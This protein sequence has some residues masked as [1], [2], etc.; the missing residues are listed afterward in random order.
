MGK[1]Q[2][3][4]HDTGAP[5]SERS[6]MDIENIVEMTI[7]RTMPSMLDKM[8]E[9]IEGALNNRAEIL[10]LNRGLGKFKLF[11]VTYFKT[12]IAAN[13]ALIIAIV[14]A[15]ILIFDK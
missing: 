12:T 10:S 4:I 7:E 9:K 1:D 8:E 3:V 15:L 5:L 11:G 13:L 14:T 2:T 6:K